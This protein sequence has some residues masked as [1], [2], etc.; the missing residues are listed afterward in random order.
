MDTTRTGFCSSQSGEENTPAYPLNPVA[1]ASVPENLSESLPSQSY[2][3]GLCLMNGLPLFSEDGQQWI[4]GRAGSRIS[5][6][7]LSKLRLPWQRH[8]DSPLSAPSSILSQNG[9]Q[10]PFPSNVEHTAMMFCSSMQFLVFPLLSLEHFVRR[11]LPLATAGSGSNQHGVQSARACAYGV[12]VTNDIF[13]HNTG[14][15]MPDVGSECA[16]YAI[17]IENSLPMILREVKTDGLEA[18]AMLIVYKY[19]IGDLQSA[20]FLISIATRLIFRLG[21]HVRPE[22]NGSYDKNNLAHHMRDLFWI[23]Y[24]FDKDLSHR[25]GQPPSI[26]DHHC[27]LTLPANYAEMQSSNILTGD[28]ASGHNFY[29]VPLYPWDLRLSIIKSKIYEDLYSLS[30]LR[31]PEAE[32]LRRIRYLDEELEI[33]RITL[34]IDHRPTLSFLEQTPVDANT[35][36]QAIMLRL[37]YHHCITLIHKARCMIFGTN[38]TIRNIVDEGHATNLQLLV[39]ASKSILTYLEKALPVL[40]HECFWIIIFY[41]MTAIVTIFSVALLNN[42]STPLL[43]DLERLEDFAQIIRQIPIRRLTAAEITHLDFIE[44]LVVDMSRLVLAANCQH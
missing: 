20:S 43:R 14:R 24:S 38:L 10:L 4:E 40:A 15:D 26:N 29:T 33:W 27:D 7:V 25:I 35:N 9:P 21:A 31:Q 41:P 37:S 18:L 6:A 36:T 1:T 5:S 17:E 44:E 30:G 3:E 12:I 34:P 32:I 19:F 16:R 42:K 28:G 13:G 8:H 23:C 22:T 39:D 2:L 11:T